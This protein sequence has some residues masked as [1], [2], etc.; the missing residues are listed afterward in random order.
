MNP[1]F[2]LPETQIHERSHIYLYS[3]KQNNTAHRSNWLVDTNHVFLIHSHMY[4]LLFFLMSLNS[5]IY[6]SLLN[7]L[8]TEESELFC[9]IVKEL[10][11]ISLVLFSCSRKIK[12]TCLFAIIR[13]I[14]LCLYILTVV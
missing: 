7:Q 2:I 10:L 9:Y 6:Y 4:I 1:G 8:E 12:I 3:I 14:I 5:I 11:N 13:F